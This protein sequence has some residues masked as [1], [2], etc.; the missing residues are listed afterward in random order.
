M[1]TLSACFSYFSKK[2]N[3]D[4]NAVLLK[5]FQLGY[6]QMINFQLPSCKN[7]ACRVKWVGYS[8]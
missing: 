4:N 5:M 1:Y 3:N 8:L 7:E 6:K 2:I